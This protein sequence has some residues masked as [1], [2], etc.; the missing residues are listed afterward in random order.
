MT[1]LYTITDNLIRNA[2]RDEKL[3]DV[4]F[5]KAYRKDK[6]E[7]PVSGFLGVVN[8]KKAE[9]EMSAEG[10]IYRTE[11]EIIL[12]NCESESG[13]ALGITA[14]NLTKA[15]KTA[16]KDGFI[17]NM[18]VGAI[19]YDSNNGAIF[20]SVNVK[21]SAIYTDGVM[22]KYPDSENEDSGTAAPYVYINDVK[23]NGVLSLSVKEE[24]ESAVSYYEIL[25]EEPW[26]S[27]AQKKGYT[28]EIS[29]S[30]DKFSDIT[31]SDFTLTAVYGES[32]VSY[33]GCRSISSEI[34]VDKSKSY[35]RKLKITATERVAQSEY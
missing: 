27:T 30:D 17:A 3:K 26:L 16:D 10:E 25:S 32:S 24:F 23:I 4:R 12:Y 19:D 2:R 1:E 8:F 5:V 9:S 18:T 35:K 6:A 20:R 15:L 22:K 34:T 21:L 13:E 31:E 33:R 7:R 28:I 29:L 11:L 14:L